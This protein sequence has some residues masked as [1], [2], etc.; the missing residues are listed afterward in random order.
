MPI[1]KPNA[2]ETES[3]FISRCLAD[4]SM[5]TEY[6]EQAQRAAVCYRAWRGED[7]ASGKSTLHSPDRAPIEAHVSL[8]FDGAPDWIMWMPGGT[9]TITGSKRGRPCTVTMRVDRKAAATM[10]QTLRDHVAASKQKPWFDFDHKG[11]AASAWPTEFAWRDNPEP[12][13]YARVEWSDVGREA[14][15]G[16]R[17]RAFSP[18]WY[19]TPSDPSEVEGAPLNMGGLVNDPAFKEISPIWAARADQETTTN[20]ND[21]TTMS[22]TSTELAA[23]QAKVAELE[24]KNKEL[25]GHVSAED[26]E[27][28]AALEAAKAEAESKSK[29]L[30]GLKREVEERK[31]RDARACV[32]SAVS[33][34]AIAA[35]DEA[36]QKQWEDMIFADPAKAELLAA[37]P[38]KVALTAG[39]ITRAPVEIIQADTNDVLRGYMAAGNPRDKGSFYAREIKPRIEKGE[40]VLARANRIPMEASNALGT[41]VNALVSQRTLDLV[42][43][44]RPQLKGVVTDFSDEVK[45]VGDTVKTRTLGLP[46][47]QNFGGTVSDTADTDVTVT[48][49]LLKEVKYTFAVTE[50]A[51]TQR[52]LIKEHAEALSVGLGIGIVDAMAALITEGNFGSTS[53]TQ[54][55]KAATSVDFSTITGIAKAMNALGVPPL[56]RFAWVDESVAE[57]LS[58]D[59]LV[60]EYFDRSSLANAYGHWRNIKGFENIWEYPALPANSC[61]L[62]AFFA[63]RSALIVAAR[64]PEN[65]TTVGSGTYIGR[66]GV[67]T[68]PISGLS[69][70]TDEYTDSSW[71][72]SSRL[73]SLFGVDVGNG[74]NTGV[75]H[76]L[77]SAA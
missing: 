44:A 42:Y 70:L 34:G 16:K 22:G 52:D 21:D 1:P 11:E 67:V 51:A 23:L 12:G 49:D 19:E 13:V 71:N 20:Q 5:L 56:G 35:K 62:I 2:G 17:Y 72:V 65:P 74:G 47:M 4:E 38:G 24:L 28:K 63:H 15:T 25:E 26:A 39:R 77:V 41:L 61:N 40:N 59:E 57:A 37:V 60:M 33:R 14:I 45:S 48:L 43:S 55:I 66:I 29:E 36:K 30:D 76:T 64:I 54:T 18:K 3:E 8:P 27:A 6:P 9:H 69:V 58:N 75:G 32:A 7:A 31:R 46:T 50:Y 68:D 10:Q 53:A 73:V